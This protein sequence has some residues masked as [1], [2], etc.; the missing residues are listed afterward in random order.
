MAPGDDPGAMLSLD[1]ASKF[2][3]S[4]GSA[5][6]ALESAAQR[7]RPEA[8]RGRNDAR[9]VQCAARRRASNDAKL[10]GWSAISRRACFSSAS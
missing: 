9:P 3:R 4:I 1:E 6:H 10:C 2:I 5:A 8:A 7:N